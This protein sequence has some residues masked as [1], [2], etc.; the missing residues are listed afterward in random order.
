MLFRKTTDWR[1]NC[2]SESFIIYDQLLIISNIELNRV[3]MQNLRSFCEI[4]EG[5]SKDLIMDLRSSI[6][7]FLSRFWTTLFWHPVLEIIRTQKAKKNAHEERKKKKK[8][9]KKKRK[10]RDAPHEC[11]ASH[12]IKD[13]TCEI[14]YQ[15]FAMTFRY[16]TKT[17]EILHGNSV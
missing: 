11:Y 12:R 10:T 4:T 8:K 9:K 15:I 3:S 14:R 13:R 16:F 2:L 17:P 6:S 5:P 7:V 1:F